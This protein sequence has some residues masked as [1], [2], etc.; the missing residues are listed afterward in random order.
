MRTRRRRAA[1]ASETDGRWTIAARCS[2]RGFNPAGR[3][4]HP[5]VF[6]AEIFEARLSDLRRDETGA[7]GAVR[8][9]RGEERNRRVPPLN[10][11]GQGKSDQDKARWRSGGVFRRCGQAGGRGR[12]RDRSNPV[13]GFHPRQALRIAIRQ[14]RCHPW[15]GARRFVWKPSTRRRL[16]GR[17]NA[18]AGRGRR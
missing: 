10:L 17:S 13:R 4:D 6:G 9:P 7:T 5:K 3:C 15:R 18:I 2:A 8:G 1:R 14:A 12:Y 11:E 16:S